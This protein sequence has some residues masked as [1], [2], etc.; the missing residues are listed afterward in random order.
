MRRLSYLFIL[1]LFFALG[2]AAPVV[3]FY[4]FNRKALEFKDYAWLSSG[5]LLNAN[6]DVIFSSGKKGLGL[7]FYE[8][9]GLFRFSIPKYILGLSKG[10]SVSFYVMPRPTDG[11]EFVA[12]SSDFLKISSADREGEWAAYIFYAD[13]DHDRIVFESPQQY[14]WAFIVVT[15]QRGLAKVYVNGNLMAKTAIWSEY[16][17]TGNDSDAK[18]IY[19][20][21]GG[22]KDGNKFNGKVDE[23]KIYNRVLWD[24]EVL[25]LSN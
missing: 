10:V 25:R 18:Y 20:Y 7:D 13:G 5:K 17:N 2:A 12:I 3:L 14:K 1:F 8:W 22:T 19:G 21:I 23:F 16:L 9:R 11:K 24:D 6:E 4:S 15:M